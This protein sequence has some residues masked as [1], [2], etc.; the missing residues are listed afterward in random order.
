MVSAKQNGYHSTIENIYFGIHTSKD[1]ETSQINES[2][3]DKKL[4]K[5]PELLKEHYTQLLNNPSKAIK[6]EGELLVKRYVED[7][8]AKERKVLIDAYKMEK[9]YGEYVKKTYTQ[10][11]KKKMKNS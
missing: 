11:D 6:Y 10:I 2:D 7:M 5:N 8:T 9:I 1:D 3:I 4:I